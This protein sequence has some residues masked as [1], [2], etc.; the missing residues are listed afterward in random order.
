MSRLNRRQKSTI[1]GQETDDVSRSVNKSFVPQVVTV[2]RGDAT[3]KTLQ[4]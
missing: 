3:T 4:I 1:A 2:V